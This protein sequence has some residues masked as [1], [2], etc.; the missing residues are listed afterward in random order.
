MAMIGGLPGGAIDPGSGG[1]RPPVGEGRPV[2]GS[3]AQ[4]GRGIADGSIVEG[5][6][7]GRDNDMYQVK[8]GVQTMNARSTAPLFVGQRFRAVWDASTSPPMLRLRQEDLAVLARFT[9]RSQNVAMALLSRGMP[10][11][12]E[13]VS[14]LRRQ[15]IKS[16]GDPAKIGALAELHARGLP[17]TEQNIALIAWYMGLSPED[18][19]RIWKKIRERLR[20]KKFS[21]PRELLEVL[22]G[23]D[24]E[25]SRMFLGAHALAGRPARSG[26]DPAMLLAP[27]WWPVGDSGE[28]IRAR[29]AFSLESQDERRVWRS[30]FAFEGSSLG[31]VEG[32]VVTNGRAMSVNIKLATDAGAS[33]V[34]EAVPELRSELE[35]IPLALQY[36]GV[37]VLNKDG[38]VQDIRYGLDM[39]I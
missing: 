20:N 5:L 26:L 3:A 8:I 11:D 39:E 32:D 28:Q 35:G 21:S 27:S 22:R 13:T 15:W 4:P 19:A 30:A 25:E 34:R 33:V 36:I 38:A 37:G 9:G 1:I 6:V 7:T 2:Q 31:S 29:V 12:E 17:A 23:G 14:E 16:G 24:D 18:A 10:V